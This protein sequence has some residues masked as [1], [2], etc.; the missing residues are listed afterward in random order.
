M[1]A[2]RTKKLAECTE[3]GHT[4]SKEL[5][6][7]HL[8]PTLASDR[9]ELGSVGIPHSEPAVECQVLPLPLVFLLVGG[10]TVGY[11]VRIGVGCALDLSISR[12]VNASF[13]RESLFRRPGGNPRRRAH[14]YIL[15]Q[16]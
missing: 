4:R 8:I 7:I 16:H 2:G 12:C 11:T 6:V 9:N 13:L 10:H 1:V 14:T 3:T 5:G 15:P